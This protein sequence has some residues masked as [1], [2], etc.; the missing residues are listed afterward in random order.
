M[1]KWNALNNKKLEELWNNDIC[2]KDIAN[3]FKTGTYAVAKQRSNLGLVHRKMPKGIKRQTRKLLEHVSEKPFYA[4]YYCKDGKNHFSLLNTTH[5]AE[6]LSIARSMVY[7]QKLHDVTLLQPT[8]KL[9]CETVR[10]IRL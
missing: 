5:E 1:I 3:I 10:T 4:L 8:T 2:D 7:S 6:A 9:I